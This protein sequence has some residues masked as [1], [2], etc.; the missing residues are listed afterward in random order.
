MKSLLFLEIPDNLI[1]MEIIKYPP[2]F[3]RILFSSPTF[4]STM[5]KKSINILLK[6]MEPNPIR[7][8]MCFGLVTWFS[9]SP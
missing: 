3:V 7:K 2:H 9:S 1:V 5:F 4:G 8:R 6:V